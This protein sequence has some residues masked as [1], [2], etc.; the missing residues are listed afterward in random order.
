MPEDIQQE[1]AKRDVEVIAIPMNQT[2]AVPYLR[3]EEDYDWLFFTS[4]NAVNYFDFSQLR[5]QAKV[6]AIG[7]QTNKV[8][9][10]K[11]IKVDFQPKR[12]F[13]EGLVHEWVLTVPA[14]QKV[15]WPH[16]QHARRVIYDSL[17]QAGHLVL[18]QIIYTNEFLPEDQQRLAKLLQETTIDY[19]LFASPSAWESFYQSVQ[20]LEKLPADF[21]QQL[22]L[23][24]IGPVTAKAIQKSGQQTVLQPE[25]F[26][27]PHLYRCLLA[28]IDQQCR[29]EVKPS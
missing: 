24:A 17:T 3:L 11:G 20:Q 25:I 26:D 4:V 27:M 18:E 15:F 5:P 29:K 16:S 21:W 22:Q 10:N 6:L 9:E 8:L 12:G 2:R 13:S 1:L 14:K 23:A 28:Q 7:N 19:A